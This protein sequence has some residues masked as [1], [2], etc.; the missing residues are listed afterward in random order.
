MTAR[1]G[2]HPQHGGD[3]PSPCRPDAHRKVLKRVRHPTVMVAG[4]P[5]SVSNTFTVAHIHHIVVA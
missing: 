2:A 3:A 4:I 5:P 1:A